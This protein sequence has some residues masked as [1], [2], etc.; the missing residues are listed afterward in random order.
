MTVAMMLL[1]F[2]LTGA[3][4]GGSPVNSVAAIVAETH[5][6]ATPSVTTEIAVP[7][8]TPIASPRA[9]KPKPV[10]QAARERVTGVGTR[11]HGWCPSGR[12][13]RDQRPAGL[14]APESDCQSRGH[15]CQRLVQLPGS[16]GRRVRADRVP[17]WISHEPDQTE[18][19]RRAVPIRRH[20]PRNRFTE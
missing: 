15:K 12:R 18:R 1:L 16:P 19:R 10:P 6:P 5:A 8:I 20:H 13:R 7:S 17:S 2:A 3:D 4:T 11:Q 9:A 14:A